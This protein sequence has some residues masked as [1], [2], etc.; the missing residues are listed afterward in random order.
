MQSKRPYPEGTG[1][2]RILLVDDHPLLREGLAQRLS[3]EPD[4]AVC[5]QAADAGEAIR[6]LEQT[7]PD[8]MIVDIAI[9]GRDGIELIK[10]VK[11]QHPRLQVLVLS[12][13]DESLYAERALHA[14]ARGYAVKSEPPERLVHAIRRVIAGE[15]AVS[16]NLVMRLLQRAT[17]THPAGS[18]S[19]VDVLTD[20]ELEIFRLLGEGH[21]RSRIAAE[22]HLSV[23]TVEAHRA[24]IR[25]K[26]GLR[27]ATEVLQHAIHFVQHESAMKPAD[28]PDGPSLSG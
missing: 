7:Q 28:S 21:Q 1:K 15:I 16:Q 2:I 22:L 23:K 10:D 27:N 14:G 25:Q 24:N 4:M 20:R 9:P 12:M 13:F 6:A 3:M 11:A 19:T 5:G 8:L 18:T 26:L 17:G